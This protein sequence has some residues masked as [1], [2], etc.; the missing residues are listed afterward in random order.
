[1][2]NFMC[3]G[4]G[5]VGDIFGLGFILTLIFW[6]LI[7]WA[8][9]AIIRHFGRNRYEQHDNQRN[10][11]RPY[12]KFA[13]RREHEGRGRE[14]KSMDRDRDD[15]ALAILRERYARGEINREEYE[16]RKQDLM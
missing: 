14:Y 12:D 2:R 6:A 8:I 13:S 4:F 9:V 16:A 5:G 10:H 7:I 3:G 11:Q 1:M 15:A